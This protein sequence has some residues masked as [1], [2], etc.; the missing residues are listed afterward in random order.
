MTAGIFSLAIFVAQVLI[1]KGFSDRLLRDYLERA[2]P[3][4]SLQ[5]SRQCYRSATTLSRHA[6]SYSLFLNLLIISRLITEIENPSVIGG[7]LVGIA[8]ELH[9]IFNFSRCVD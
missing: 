3:N 7:K 1:V 9:G 8:L 2:S 6:A 5:A 4:S